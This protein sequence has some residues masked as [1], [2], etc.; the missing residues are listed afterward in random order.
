[1]T[2]R[3]RKLGEALGAEILDVDPASPL[4]ERS[5]GEVRRLWLEHS[6]LLFRGVEWTPAQHIAFTRHFG[7]LHIM[8]R[9][10]TEVPVNLREYPEIF[11]VSTLEKDGTPVG[12]RRAGWGWH[13]DG[14]D[15]EFPN[16]ASMLYGV[17]TPKVGGDTAFASTYKAYE[18]LPEATRAVI[19]GRRARF[20]R[21]EKHRI[22]YPNLPPLTETEKQARPD[23]WHPIVR[24]HPETLRKCLYVGRWAVEIDGMPAA[25]GEDLI[26]ELTSHITKP[27]FTYIHKWRPGDVVL[28]DNRCTQHCAI[29]YDDSVEERH[30]LRT[31]LEGDL[32]FYLAA[33]G[34]RIESAL[35]L[36]A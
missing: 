22:N 1:M 36:P 3:I 4:D 30:M 25:E 7:E 20:S 5:V 35:A 29:P 27:E 17:K 12:L 8:P 32:P 18:A 11:V 15:K 26:D 19:D 13:S 21:I 31:T 28:W 23:V 6:V 24:T 10:G 33:D 9:I 2:I 34:S 14:E 16:M